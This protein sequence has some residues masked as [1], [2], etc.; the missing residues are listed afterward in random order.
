MLYSIYFTYLLTYLIKFYTTPVADFRLSVELRTVTY[1][2]HSHN[3][4]IEGCLIDF[5]I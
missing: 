2:D 5:H 1:L 3:V 4:M